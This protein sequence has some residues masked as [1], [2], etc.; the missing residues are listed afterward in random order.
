VW[1]GEE[2]ADTDRLKALLVPFP[3]EGMTMITECMPSST[4]L[5]APMAGRS[6]RPG[7]AASWGQR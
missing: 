3:A 1:R 6:R 2:P 5:A 4:T 7:C